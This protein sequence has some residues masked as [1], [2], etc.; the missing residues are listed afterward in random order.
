[1]AEDIS[2]NTL[3]HAHPREV[4]GLI[5]RGKWRQPTAVLCLGRVQTNL[6]ILPR[7]LAYDFLLFAQRNPK[8]CPVLEVTEPGSIE[9]VQTAPGADLRQDLPKYRIYRHGQLDAEVTDLMGIWQD[10]LVSFLLGCSFTFEAAM[11]QAGVPVR[12]LEEGKNVPMYITNRPC[13]PAGIFQGPLVVSMRPVLPSLIPQAVQ[14]TARFPAVH[15]G[16]IHVGDPV[17]LGIQD[18]ARPDFGDP[19]TMRAGEVPVFWACGVTPQAVAMRP[20]PP[21]RR[22][23]ILS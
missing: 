11:L 1:M 23:A 2:R 6:V 5:R 4:R 10:H 21:L 18:L 22:C 7:A 19:V 16:P 8:P 9:P 3:A 17:S 20:K 13:L 12:H 14:A 15:G